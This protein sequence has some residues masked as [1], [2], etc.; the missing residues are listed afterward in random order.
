MYLLIGFPSF[1][2]SFYHRSD[3][4]FQHGV[5]K[6]AIIDIKA[7]T[8]HSYCNLVSDIIELRKQLL[9]NAGT[10]IEDLKE[11]RVAFLCPNG[12]DYVV[13][14][15]SIW[16]AGGNAVPLCIT[17]PSS[18]LLYVLK[19]SQSSIVITH[20]DFQEKINDIARE[21]GIKK[22]PTLIPTDNSRRAMM[23]Y[24]SGTTGKPKG[25]ITTHANITAQVKSLVDA[26]RWNDKDKI[27]HVLPLHH[28]HGVINALTCGLYAGA[29]VEMMPKFDAAAV[30]N[31]WMKPDNDLSLFMAVPTIYSKLIQYYKENIPKEIQ[32]LATK[33]CS[34][35]RLMVSGSSALPISIRNSWKEI[36]GGVVLLER[37]GMTEIGMA[38]SHEYE[39]EKRYEGC[40]GIPLPGVQVRL[41]SEDGKDVTSLVEQPGELNV[42]GPN[43]FKEYWNRPEATKKEFTED[44]WFKTGD[45]AMITAREKVFK[46]LGRQ[47]VDIIKSGSYKL[48]AL[49]IEKELLSHPNIQEI[50]IVGIEDQE[51]GQKVGAIIVLKN[52]ES[53]LD[54]K[55]L[56]E[57]AKD[58]LAHYKLPTLLK[59]INEIPRNAMG[60]V[61]KK[62]LVKLFAD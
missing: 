26:W 56:R 38:L 40:V 22:P 10:S 50:S 14:Q 44:G 17:H 60:K 52:Q 24:T 1:D 15:W 53:K 39:I 9:K 51:W 25:V 46:I 61:N 57:F 4:I 6:P 58:K 23:I 54:L 16:S 3:L 33:S 18:E 30:W 20:S 36:S 11:A 12:Y 28:L 31:R 29:T 48:S 5:L 49:E 35:F 19:D 21:A 34:Q 8:S 7:G 55:Q 41:I 43:V 2:P 13:S 32:P 62:E 59:V 47:S 45:I 37:Y 42:K 27:L